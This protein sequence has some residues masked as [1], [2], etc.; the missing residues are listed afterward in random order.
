MKISCSDFSVS[1]HAVICN[2]KGEV[3]GWGK[4]YYFSE[5][6][7]TNLPDVNPVEEGESEEKINKKE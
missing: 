4:M 2:S 5:G 7:P 6:E 3:A 1:S